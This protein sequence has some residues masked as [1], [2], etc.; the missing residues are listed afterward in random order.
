MFGR[1]LLVSLADGER[2]GALHKT[3]RPL[4]VFFHIHGS[5]PLSAKSPRGGDDCAA[6]MLMP[7]AAAFAEN[8]GTGRGNGRGSDRQ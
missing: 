6:G 4:G 8:V 3:A 7:L 2:L 5:L 1:E